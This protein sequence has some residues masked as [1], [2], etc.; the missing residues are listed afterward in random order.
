MLKS[1]YLVSQVSS[2]SWNGVYPHLPRQD[3][4]FYLLSGQ[5]A[6]LFGLQKGALFGLGQWERMS[7]RLQ[8]GR[9]WKGVLFLP[10]PRGI[11]SGW[12]LL[13]AKGRFFLYYVS[14]QPFSFCVPVSAPSSV[15]SAL[16]EA[17][18]PQILACGFCTTPYGLLCP[19]CLHNQPLIGSSSQMILLGSWAILIPSASPNWSFLFSV[20]LRFHWH[21]TL[22]S[23]VQSSVGNSSRSKLTITPVIQQA[24][25]L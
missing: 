8:R 1:W 10:S 21:A 22:F 4:F 11:S 7:N 23:C 20:V 13:W 19:A 25:T 3:F 14:P 9:K 15:C 5:E 18:A 16:G 2:L 12:L 24:I 17:A 6:D